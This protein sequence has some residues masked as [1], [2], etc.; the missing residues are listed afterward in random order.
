MTN[1]MFTAVA[2]PGSGAH[3]ENVPDFETL[4]DGINYYVQRGWRVG[5]RAESYAKMELWLD[6][7]DDP[8]LLF[9]NCPDKIVHIGPLTASFLSPFR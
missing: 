8:M 7:S 6:H 5:E 9:D 4:E 3:V 1:Q 2:H